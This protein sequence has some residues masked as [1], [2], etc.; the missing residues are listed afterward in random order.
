MDHIA[1]LDVAIYSLT[2]KVIIK[3]ALI[4]PQSM[5]THELEVA[6]HTQGEFTGKFVRLYLGS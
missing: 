5:E 6:I 4:F 1:F 2:D 3:P